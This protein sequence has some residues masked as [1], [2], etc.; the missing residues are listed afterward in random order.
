[1]K[2]PRLRNPLDAADRKLL[3]HAAVLVATAVGSVLLTAATLVLA[4]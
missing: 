1:M 3:T 4:C 2:R